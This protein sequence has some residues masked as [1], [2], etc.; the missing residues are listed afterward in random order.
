[1]LTG[2]EFRFKRM[3]IVSY[4]L[5]F[6]T[7][8]IDGRETTVQN[9][10][11]LVSAISAL[12]QKIAGNSMADLCQTIVW[13]GKSDAPPATEI[14]AV[15]CDSPIS[16]D[17]SDSTGRYQMVPV[18]IEQS[19]DDK[20]Y[21]GFCNDCIWPLFHY[22]PSLVVH[23]ESYFENY[24]AAN[25]LFAD[26]L[27]TIIQPDD[28]IWIHDYHLFLLPALIRNDFPNANIGFFLHIPFPSF[29]I[30]RIM[31]GTGARQSLQACSV[32]T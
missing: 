10:G 29:E 8:I 14:P 28:F 24:Q 32:Q 3:V 31:P 27:K 18:N 7:V 1:M 11:G 30:F 13:V 16:K 22:F 21:G 26:K 2:K 12:S 4:R 6:K 23:D 17:A 15:S 25:E 20:Y 5:P 9:S 19:I